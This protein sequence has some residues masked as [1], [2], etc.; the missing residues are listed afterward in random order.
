MFVLPGYS[1]EYLG[2]EVWLISGIIAMVRVREVINISYNKTWT[3]MLQTHYVMWMKVVH[4]YF[5]FVPRFLNRFIVLSVLSRFYGIHQYFQNWANTHFFFKFY[6]HLALSWQCVMTM[7]NI[8]EKRKE[9]HQ[10]H[11]TQWWNDTTGIR[12]VIINVINFN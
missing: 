7:K 3:K 2:K 6:D 1:L 11:K 8:K 4:T 10:Q 5:I 12:K 9:K